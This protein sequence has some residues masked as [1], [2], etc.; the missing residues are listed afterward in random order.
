MFECKS[1]AGCMVDSWR[2]TFLP[3][4]LLFTVTK[5][6]LIVL[7]NRSIKVENSVLIAKLN[8]STLSL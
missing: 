4:Y 5:G 2:I 8:T 7:E 6:S 3:C 1:Y